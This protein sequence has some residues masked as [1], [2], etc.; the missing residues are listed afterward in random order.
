MLLTPQPP[1]STPP[2]DAHEE[3]AYRGEGVSELALARRK[4]VP[5]VGAWPTPD[6]NPPVLMAPETHTGHTRCTLAQGSAAAGARPRLASARELDGL[7]MGGARL[8]TC[9]PQTHAGANHG[10]VWVLVVLLWL[11]G[12]PAHLLSPGGDGLAVVDDDV[13]EGVE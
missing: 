10:G 6:P 7:G 13:E 11:V 2:L 9:M 4:H 1:S 3:S 8:P 12:A 5:G